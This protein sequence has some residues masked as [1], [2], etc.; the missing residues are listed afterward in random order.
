MV[1]RPFFLTLFFQKPWEVEAMICKTVR[2][3]QECPFMT[4]SGCS[5]NGGVC[6]EIVEHC[7]GCNR[8]VEFNSGWYC[9]ASPEPAKRWQ[10]GK[11]VDYVRQFLKTPLGQKRGFLRRASMNF[12][13]LFIPHRPIILSFITS[14]DSIAEETRWDSLFKNTAAPQ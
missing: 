6:H 2:A 14:M 1:P 13:L 3:G 12:F 8:T 4:A 5:Y 7:N 9:S 11:R 10:V